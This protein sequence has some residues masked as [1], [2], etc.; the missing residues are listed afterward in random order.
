[1]ELTTQLSCRNPELTSTVDHCVSARWIG[2][3]FNSQDTAMRLLMKR[4]GRIPTQFCICCARVAGAALLESKIGQPALRPWHKTSSLALL[5]VLLVFCPPA[6]NS[7]LA[8]LVSVQRTE[9][10]THGFLTLRSSDGK[11]LAD[12]EINQY[13][14]GDL[15]RSHL[16]FHFRDG[17]LYEEEATFS[18]RGKFR[19]RSDHLI[20]RGPSFEHPIETSIDVATGRVKVHYIDADGKPNDVDQHMELPEDIAN[21]LLFTLM[22]H[23][24]PH[25]S[26][27]VVSEVAMTPE[28][29]LV[30]LVIRRQGDEA[31]STGAVR[32]EAVHY[33]VHVKL[34]GFAG[35]VA[36][37]FG[38][39]PPDMH[40]WI[41]R[42]VVPAFVKF[43]GPIC[44]GGPVWRV[45]MGEPA[46]FQ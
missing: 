13:A 20:Q 39:Q 40:I 18:Q 15:V 10:L 7:A 38:K 2:F 1:M 42:G 17:S 12:G 37:L 41:K 28:P 46:K 19:L 23:L 3:G 32:H 26:T 16:V 30:Q 14:E 35:I 43:E 21:G 45:E 5:S 24:D 36:P 11:H 9:G 8:E 25:A 34:G 4:I 27:T 6:L 29:R 31:F 44:N 33:V 22:R